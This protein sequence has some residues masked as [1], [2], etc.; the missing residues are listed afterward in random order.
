M[1][2]PTTETT[3][4][5][6]RK[7]DEILLAMKKRGFGANLYNGV[8]GKIDAGERI[9]EAVIRECQEEIGVIPHKLKQVAEL[10][11]DFTGKDGVVHSHM[12]V[13]V[14]VSTS[15]QGVPIETEEMAPEWFK[16]ANIP[17]ETMWED[18]PYWLPIVLAGKQIHGSF[19]FDPNNNL[20][21]STTTKL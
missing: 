17:Y 21:K 14:F 1:A 6:L 5:F 12:H 13:H 7:D 9:E 11:F 4:L 18:D 3:L 2:T 16:L 8:G 19:T 20:V 10:D 15:W